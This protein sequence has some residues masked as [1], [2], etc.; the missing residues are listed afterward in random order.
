MNTDYCLHIASSGNAVIYKYASSSN[1]K[2]AFSR[3]GSGTYN[4]KNSNKYVSV[5]NSNV[6]TMTSYPTGTWSFEKVKLGK[7]SMF[8]FQYSGYD[9]T[10]ENTYIINNLSNINYQNVYSYVN[11]SRDY[12]FRQMPLSDIWIHNG[13]GATGLMHFTSDG[14][15]GGNIDIIKI[16]NLNNNALS[17]ERAIIT[18]GCKSG[19]NVYSTVANENNNLIEAMYEKGAHFAIG[20]EDEILNY[21]AS[22]WLRLF[23]QHARG[24]NSIRD[25]IIYANHFM[26]LGNY[27]YAGDTFQVLSR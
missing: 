6:Q 10:T 13:H 9:S 27:H 23:T 18:T 19:G 17:S 14:S 20:W 22:A 24:E 4:I 26:A 7:I 2:F 16:N 3:T 11:N 5:S 15:N 21:N 12:A 1:E 25:C 8:S